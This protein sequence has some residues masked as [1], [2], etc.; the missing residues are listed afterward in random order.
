[1]YCTIPKVN[2]PDDHGS[3][4]GAQSGAGEEA[5]RTPRPAPRQRGSKSRGQVGSGADPTAFL[6]T[7]PPWLDRTPATAQRDK[8]RP[9]S[10]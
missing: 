8:A 2:Y 5:D 7:D 9:G 4:Q 6:P 10:T 3:A 1:M